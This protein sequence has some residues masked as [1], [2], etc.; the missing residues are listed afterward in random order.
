MRA[1]GA[2]VVELAADGDLPAER[3]RE[4]GHLAGVLSL[5]RCDD[6]AECP[7]GLDDSAPL[8]AMTDGAVS[9]GRSDPLANPAQAQI[10]GLRRVAALEYP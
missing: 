4:S 2:E 8:W 10:W 7:A 9:I 3:I 5:R 6:D 1:A